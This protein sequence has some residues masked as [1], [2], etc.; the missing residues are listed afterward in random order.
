MKKRVNW[1]IMQKCLL[2]VLALGFFLSCQ[3][4]SGETLVKVG[5]QAPEFSVNMFDGSVV[6]LKDLKGK[7]VLLNFWATWCPPCRLEL[8]RV[9]KD[10]ID[11]FAGEDFVFC[12]FP[13]RIPMKR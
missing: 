3:A 13:G 6:S 11:R 8:N 9:Q 5:Q 2:V 10:I 1:V 7:V 4:Q 12:L